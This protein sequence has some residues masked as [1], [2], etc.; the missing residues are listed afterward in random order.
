M[1][2]ES[3]AAKTT[4]GSASSSNA[5][6]VADLGSSKTV[7]AI[8]YGGIGPEACGWEA[9]EPWFGTAQVQYSTNGSS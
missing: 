4:W 6:I 5:N 1:N 2:D 8:R 9:C 3:T 7:S